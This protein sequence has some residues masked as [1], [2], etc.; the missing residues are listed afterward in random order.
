M[1]KKEEVIEIL[2]SIEN[3]LNY[4][5]Y[6]EAESKVKLNVKIIELNKNRHYLKLQ[7]KL[8]SL[9]NKKGLTHKDTIKISQKIDNQINEIYK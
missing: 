4:D 9:I 2:K 1:Y 8:N 5:N 3:K 7:N 6:K